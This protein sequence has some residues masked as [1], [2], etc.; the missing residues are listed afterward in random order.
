MRLLK[1]ASSSTLS[2]LVA[3]LFIGC[4]QSERLSNQESLSSMTTY[5]YRDNAD[6][7]IF[8]SSTELLWTQE[9]SDTPISWESAEDYCKSLSTGDIFT[10]RLPNIKE[11][12]SIRDFSKAWPW[13]D[14]H[15]FHLPSGYY[16][17]GFVFNNCSEDSKLFSS[18]HF[19][20]CVSGDTYG[21]SE[22]VDNRDATVSDRATGL[23]WTQNDSGYTM[24]WEAALSYAESSEY[25]GY[26]DWRLPNIKEMQSITQYLGI[27]AA[28]D[29]SFF[30]TSAIFNESYSADCQYY[31]RS[32]SNLYLNSE[33]ESYYHYVVLVRG[34]DSSKTLNK[35]LDYQGAA[36]QLGVT[37]EA[38]EAAL[39]SSEEDEPNYR[40]IASALGVAESALRA[41][42]EQSWV[43]I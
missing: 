13:V 21:S 24:T 7:T 34:G 2:A 16:D 12:Y 11:L 18:Q 29:I 41:A 4:A 36:I 10:W 22:Y 8:D 1:I 17:S 25:A 35:R 42:L 38:L 9:L 26:S 32:S 23:M 20:R 5:S 28:I 15:Y 27:F 3:I 43:L 31:W 6:G 19:V 37:Q 40:D 39:Y 14:T 33:G 30:S